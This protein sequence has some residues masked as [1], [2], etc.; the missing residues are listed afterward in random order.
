MNRT[1]YLK[2]HRLAR[3]GDLGTLA[4]QTAWP[5]YQFFLT[6]VHDLRFPRVG[7]NRHA[8]NGAR[9]DTL[10]GGFR[11]RHWMRLAQGR[12]AA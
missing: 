11:L 12:R 1:Q 3:R 7:D 8:L 6:E 10:R 4:V 9:F 2:F 5:V